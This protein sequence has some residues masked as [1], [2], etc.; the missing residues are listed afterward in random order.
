MARPKTYQT[1]SK[2][3]EKDKEKIVKLARERYKRGRESQNN[4]NQKYKDNIRFCFEPDYQWPETIR[5]ARM[6]DGR[7]C[8]SVNRMPV[9]CR[10]ITNDYKRNSSGIKVIAGS[11]GSEEVAEILTG[12]VRNIET[13]SNAPQVKGMALG[14]AV[15]G[16]KGFYRVITQIREGSFDE[17]EIKIEPIVN[18]TSVVYDC[19][20]VSLDGSGWKWAFIEDMITEEE[21]KDRYPDEDMDSWSS[22]LSDWS[23]DGGKKIRIAEY[24]YKEMEKTNLCLIESGEVV[25]ESDLQEGMVV[26]DQREADMPIVRWC[27]LGGNASKPLEEK[28]WAGKYIPIVPVWGDQLWI[29]GKRVLLSALEFSHDA[30]RMLNFYRSSETELLSLQNKAPYILTPTQVEG[31]ENQWGGANSSNS[32]YLL[33]NPDPQA[34]MPQRAPFPSPP[35][36]V[37]QGAA[38]AAQDIMDTSG[39][40][41][42]GLGMQSNETSGRAIN[43]RA[44]QGEKATFHILDNMAHADVYCGRILIDLIPHIYDTPRIER[45][46][47]FDGSAEMKAINQPTEEKDEYGQAVVKMYDLSVGNYDVIPSSAPNFQSLR[48]EGQQMLTQLLTGNPQLMSQA[49]DILMKTM[50]IPYADELSERLKKFLPQGIA[51]AEDGAPPIPPELQAQMEQMQ[52]QMQEMDQMLQQQAQELQDKQ[53][54]YAIEMEK[55]RVQQFDAE[56]KRIAVT[57]PEVGVSVQADPELSEADKIEIDLV[58]KVRMKEMDQEHDIKKTVLAH[59]L[60]R[61]AEKDYGEMEDIDETG[62]EKPSLIIESMTQ[63]QQGMAQ[64]QASLQAMSQAIANLTAINAAPKRVIKDENGRPIGIE[65]V[66]Q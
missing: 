55:V 34:A 16:N 49:G 50:D 42:A 41:E 14:Y 28:E 8:I 30:Q 19:D 11:D 1:A 44:A 31:F 3:K 5:K 53:A 29:D 9:F 22:D 62:E 12:L 17:Q 58:Q 66:L 45:I 4:E 13:Q 46:M 60:Q 47:G 20:D 21:F 52:A 26:V 61:M 27:I 25:Y 56:T 2:K 51:P 32:P 33:A 15:A 6:I 54:Q 63:V 40:Q 24:F 23:Q 65:P 35:T 36:G 59:K 57:K 37:L 10:S 39:I 7:P 48:Q 43:A 64:T 38:N 18:T